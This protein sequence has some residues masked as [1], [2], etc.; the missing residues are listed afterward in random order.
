MGVVEP[1][2]HLLAERLRAGQAEIP[3]MDIV[4]SLKRELV[5]PRTTPPPGGVAAEAR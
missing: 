3:G 5:A 1:R 2:D 4:N